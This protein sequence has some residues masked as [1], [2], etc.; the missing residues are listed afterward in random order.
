MVLRTGALL[1]ALLLV[2]PG[3][4]Q[5]G[6]DPGEVASNFTCFDTSGNTRELYEF[7][8]QVIVLNFSA[9]W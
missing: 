6:G 3:F 9:G 8:G 4:A 2:L 7:W 1:L 5:A